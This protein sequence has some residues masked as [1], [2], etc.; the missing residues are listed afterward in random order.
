MSKVGIDHSTV[1]DGHGNAD[2][3]Y[4]FTRDLCRV[5]VHHRKVTQLDYTLWLHKQYGKVEIISCNNS[6]Y[7]SDSAI[8]WISLQVNSKDGIYFAILF[9]LRLLQR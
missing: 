7:H 4:G 5:A 8:F 2:V 3:F 1:D 6:Q 9:T